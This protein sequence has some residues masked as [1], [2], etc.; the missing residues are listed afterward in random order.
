MALTIDY[1]CF[2]A[3]LI[4]KNE[5][6]QSFF[7]LCAA[8]VFRGRR[9]TGIAAMGHSISRLLDYLDRAPDS[10]NDKADPPQAKGDNRQ[11]VEKPG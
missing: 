3:D 4:R 9:K 2:G 5:N 6:H 1:L 10:F 8:R 7:G 11:N